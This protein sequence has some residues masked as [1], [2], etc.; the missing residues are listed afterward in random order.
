MNYVDLAQQITR[1]TDELL[2]LSD[3]AAR[4][5]YVA[6]I[7][8]PY[9]PKGM[10]RHAPQQDVARAFAGAGKD[11]DAMLGNA[12]ATVFHTISTHEPAIR[13]ALD[14]ARRPL[15][16][17]AAHEKRTGQL[18]LTTTESSLLALLDLTRTQRL[19][20]RR[21]K[22]SQLLHDYTTALADETR[23]ESS[24][25]VRFVEGADLGAM[26]EGVVD[27][28]REP[29]EVGAL[30]S[31]RQR[32]AHARDA[33]IPSDLRAAAEA[34]DRARRLAERAE[35]VTRAAIAV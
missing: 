3:P 35:N 1:P 6:K 30:A 32:I 13:A 31:L 34:I 21:V 4:D 7:M 19:E 29:A 8:E 23:Q 17:E 33:R 25:V 27:A 14:E 18:G 24:T 16:W 11:F 9:G 12:V 2:R 15:T 28:K 20:A 5:A 10:W 26:F 22:P